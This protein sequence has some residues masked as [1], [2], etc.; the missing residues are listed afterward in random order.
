MKKAKI[1]ISL[2][3]GPK[4]GDYESCRQH[5][6]IQGDPETIA[7]MFA[8]LLTT[9]PRMLLIIRDALELQDRIVDMHRISEQ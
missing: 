3:P 5:V 1:E 8:A 7:K 4:V 9:E 2:T 6:V